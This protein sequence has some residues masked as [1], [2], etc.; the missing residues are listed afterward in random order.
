[1]A[2]TKATFLPRIS[3]ATTLLLLSL[4]LGPRRPLVGRATATRHR[5]F[6]T[7]TYSRL[8]HR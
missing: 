1:L 3:W 8:A 7:P 6:A 5:P 2:T 4:A